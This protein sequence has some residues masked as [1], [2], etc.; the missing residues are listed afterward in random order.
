MNKVLKI[1]FES[2]WHVGSGAGIPG[3]V[4][5]TVQKDANEI[6]YV[7]G[8]TLT[9][10]LR[11][12]A[13]FIADVRDKAENGSSWKK[14]L[15]SLF[16]GQ[17][18]KNEELKEAK[19]GIEDAVFSDE[20]KNTF[21]CHNALAQALF[22]VKPGVKINRETG[23]AEDDHLFFREEVRGG[24]T[25]YANIHIEDGLT[26]AGKKLL[27]DAIKATRKIGGHR[28]RGSGQCRI[29]LINPPTVNGLSPQP[30]A[31]GTQ[32]T[33]CVPTIITDGGSVELEY[34]LETLQPVI[35]NRVTL[36][37]VVQSEPFI[38]GTF[39]LPFFNNKI[40]S[41][42][43]SGQIKDA[44]G[45]GEFSVGPFYPEV[46]NNLA[47]PVPF[48]YSRE[49]E[50]PSV[51]KNRLV[52]PHEGDS[53][54]KDVRSGFVSV[55]PMGGP[56]AVT[57]SSA[58]EIMIYRTHNA[59]EDEK[60]RPSEDSG[61]P[62]TYQAIKS[63]VKF[64]GTIRI[65]GDFWANIRDK[66][67]FIRKLKEKAIISIG[68][69]KKDE[70]GRVEIAFAGKAI[71]AAPSTGNDLLNGQGGKKY[72]AVY[73]A[74]DVLVRNKDALAFT[75]SVDDFRDALANTL[76]VSLINADFKER[77]PLGGDRGNCVRFGRRESWHSKWGLPRPSLVY[78]QAG[79]VFLFEVVDPNK[80]DLTTAEEKL[81]PGI[82]DRRGEGY[83][84][85]MLSPKFLCGQ[86]AK[87]SQIEP[88]SARNGHENQGNANEPEAILD[89][90]DKNFLLHLKKEHL[91]AAFVKSIRRAVADYVQ[92]NE[93]SFHLFENISLKEDSPTAS[94]FG[95][96]R[97]IAAA[98]SEIG[99]VTP[100]MPLFDAQAS[101]RQFTK[102]WGE[103]WIV[104]LE[105]VTG[106]EVDL[107][108]VLD[109]NT[110]LNPELREELSIFAIATFLDI[111]CEA[112]FDGHSREG[113]S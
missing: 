51:V 67:N 27:S 88:D 79:S 22:I 6:P 1:K 82:G 56:T 42:D 83:G 78:L 47:Y 30:D 13:E 33:P 24:C 61:G 55:S 100:V 21:L 96:L 84:R 86:G 48:S 58:G 12:S 59:V 68:Q 14:A 50:N 72:I 111:F 40:S 63:G 93:D 4:D 53:Q 36:G 80:L 2:D 45:K 44:I 104:W 7:P 28:R 10:I 31:S 18:A 66:D 77:N 37:N 60:Q 9:G 91:K 29:E 46:G 54:M 5:R 16:G 73:L 35:V 105:N 85:V 38:P 65:S 102:A 25:L 81:F 75:G 89:E 62:Y 74:S 34:V 90:G 49:K 113:R 17:P 69:S 108:G 71:K 110:L 87:I 57:L 39:L 103:N 94:Q 101:R 32:G 41:A 70:Y 23:R 98:I 19:V 20:L 76:G 109:G 26:D 107:W 95:L 8:K 52:E 92:N 64:R 3:S 15:E 112:V 99:N 97:E 11:D 106:G 43:L